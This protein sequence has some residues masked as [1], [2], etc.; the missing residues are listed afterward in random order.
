[1]EE[2]LL[3]NSSTCKPCGYFPVPQVLSAVPLTNILSAHHS[4]KRSLSPCARTRLELTMGIREK[5][6]IS[7]MKPLATILRTEGVDPHLLFTRTITS[8]LGLV[9]LVQ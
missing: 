7:A 5:Y 9:S 3:V 4:G 8:V 6:L 1:M 2:V